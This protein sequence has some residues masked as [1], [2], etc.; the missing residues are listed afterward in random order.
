MWTPHL[1]KITST[2]CLCTVETTFEKTYRKQVFDDLNLLYCPSQ[3][4]HFLRRWPLM[5][6]RRPRL[7]RFPPRIFLLS[8]TENFPC[9]RLW[10]TESFNCENYMLL[11]FWL[12]TALPP[13]VEFVSVE[14]YG[15]SAWTVTG[16][17]TARNSDGSEKLFFLK[18]YL[19]FIVFRW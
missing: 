8:W 16:K 2:H 15:N 4:K 7:V 1:S 3:L 11:V 17:V 14:S 5:L 6:R 18:V 19:S 13:G 9:A 12:C 10:S